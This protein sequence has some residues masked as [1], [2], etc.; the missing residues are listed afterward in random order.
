[1][2]SQHQQS[3]LKKVLLTVGLFLLSATWVFAQNGDVRT[4]N[5]YGT[6]Q[7]KYTVTQQGSKFET[8]KKAKGNVEGDQWILHAIHAKAGEKLKIVLHNKTN[9]PASAMSHNWVLLKMGTSPKKFA[10]SSSG[11][12][13]NGYINPDM[14][15][16][17][18]HKTDMVS[19]GN[20]D[21]VTFTVPEK[22]GKYDYLCTFPGHFLSGMKGKLIVE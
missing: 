22:K 15:N 10:N 19:G 5:I 7:M 16:K 13:D 8:G 1:M 20:T 21:S 14:E 2:L 17:V 4:I 12:K 6:N 11:S 9:L 3:P 18:L